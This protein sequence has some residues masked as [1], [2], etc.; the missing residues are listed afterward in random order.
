[1]A[2]ANPLALRLFN[3]DLLKT[4]IWWVALRG[5]SHALSWTKTVFT[6]CVCGDTPWSSAP[7]NATVHAMLLAACFTHLHCLAWR[8]FFYLHLT[9]CCCLP[10][11]INFLFK[12]CNRINKQCA[13][14]Y[15]VMCLCGTCADSFT[16]STQ[17]W[18]EKRGL[19]CLLSHLRKCVDV[20]APRTLHEPSCSFVGTHL[21]SE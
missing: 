20:V 15:L 10:L 14:A 3:R 8:L 13:N 19:S 6:F 1:M 12:L 2:K 4:L 11:R 7:H 9:P 5:F 16:H 17:H 21:S 18:R